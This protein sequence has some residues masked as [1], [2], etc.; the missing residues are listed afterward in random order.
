[1]PTE[2]KAKSNK[3]HLLASLT[4]VACIVGMAA[5]VITVGR[6]ARI[7]LLVQLNCKITNNIKQK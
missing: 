1:M 6:V 5:A 7:T 2:P 4:V 3:I